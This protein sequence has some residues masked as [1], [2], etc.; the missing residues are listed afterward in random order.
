M[1]D[2]LTE[3]QTAEFREAFA[4]FDKDGDGTISTKELGTVMK[5]LGQ[6]PTV[7]ELNDM[8]NEVDSDGNGEIDFDEFLSMMAKKLKETD[9]E[10]D[11]REAFRVFDKNSSGIIST[12]ELRHIMT[13]LG[14]KLK[15]SEIDEMI[16]H[17]D[18]DGDGS[19]NYNEWVTMMTSI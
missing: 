6:K 16:R 19:V 14:E 7:A 2:Q 3:E 10:E 1:A 5:S 13:N 9:L 12:M 11:I 17:A 4:L 8:I 15:D 18:I